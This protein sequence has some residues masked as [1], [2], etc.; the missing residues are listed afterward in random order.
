MTRVGLRNWSMGSCK[1]IQQIQPHH[2]VWCILSSQWIVFRGPRVY[3]VHSRVHSILHILRRVKLLA[4]DTLFITLPPPTTLPFCL[5]AWGVRGK[6]PPL[7][8]SSSS[9]P[10]IHIFNKSM[11]SLQ[12]DNYITNIAIHSLGCQTSW[13]LR[14]FGGRLNV[15]E[16]VNISWHPGH[17]KGH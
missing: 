12:R 13:Y 17:L 11:F 8:A 1:A 14:M 5:P 3:I 6:K 2:S 7:P 16:R 9:S 15:L 10:A 4:P